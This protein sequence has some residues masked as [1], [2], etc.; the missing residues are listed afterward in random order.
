[1]E[2][3]LYYL[4]NKDGHIYIPATFMEKLNLNENTPMEMY[5]ENGRIVI[6]PRK[7]RAIIT[8]EEK[9]NIYNAS[10]QD[11]ETKWGLPDIAD[12]REDEVA[13]DFLEFFLKNLGIE[14]KE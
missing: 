9:N 4:N 3:T 5:I 1:M 6:R 7:I 2:K 11:L 13:D 14:V 12:F 10:L 8:K